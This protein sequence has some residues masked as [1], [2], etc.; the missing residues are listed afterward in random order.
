MKRFP[1]LN[2]LPGSYAKRRQAREPSTSYAGVS[3]LSL[4]CVMLL[5]PE[6]KSSAPFSVQPILLSAVLLPGSKGSG[7]FYLS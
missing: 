1:G 2:F 3:H 6:A 5:L 4:H 7:A